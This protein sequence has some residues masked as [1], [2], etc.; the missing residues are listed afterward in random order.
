MSTEIPARERARRA[1]LVNG[2]RQMILN[3]YV[4]EESDDTSLTINW[5]DFY[6]QVSFSELHPLMVICFVRRLKPSSIARRKPLLNTLNLNSVFGSHAVNEDIGCYAYRYAQWLDAEL[7]PERFKE[8]LQR[9]CEEAA[10][11]Y[12]QLA[13]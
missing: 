7:H 13:A 9:S 10:R 5:D 2:A 8:I 6:L 11:G 12:L 4:V 1:G 3:S